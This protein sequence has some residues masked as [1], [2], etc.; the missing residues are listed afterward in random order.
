MS[1]IIS[2]DQKQ[3]FQKTL[4]YVLSLYDQKKIEEANEI[5]VD[6]VLRDMKL[7]EDPTEFFL[8]VSQ[9]L[10]KIPVFNGIN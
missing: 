1:K 2:N 5:F 8:F 10:S 3:R 4:D 9:E 6:F 7:Y